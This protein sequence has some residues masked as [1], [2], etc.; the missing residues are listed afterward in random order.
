M[1]TIVLNE[2]TARR[3]LGDVLRSA[4]G[5]EVRITDST[6]KLIARLLFGE[7]PAIC[8]LTREEVEKDLGDLRRRAAADR[9]GD[10]TTAQLL[11]R[12]RRIAP[13][14]PE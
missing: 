4:S 11:E 8:R 14:E 13:E 7:L 9:S 5:S 2:E 1:T 3:P 12:L 10:L 6:G